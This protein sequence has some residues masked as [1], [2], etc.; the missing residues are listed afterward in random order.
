MYDVLRPART[1]GGA[2]KIGLGQRAS[3]RMT[4]PG[5]ICAKGCDG[6]KTEPEVLRLWCG[7]V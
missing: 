7:S 2:L 4:R 5:A 3:A 6:L 1:I